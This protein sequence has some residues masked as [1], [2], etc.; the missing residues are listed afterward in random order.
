MR[1]YSHM[2]AGSHHKSPKRKVR[3]GFQRETTKVNY[4]RVSEAKGQ[5]E[6][7]RCSRLDIY[8][9][10]VSMFLLA[11]MHKNKTWRS[12]SWNVAPSFVENGNGPKCG[13][14]ESMTRGLRSTSKTE[15]GIRFAQA[16]RF[17]PGETLYARHKR[18]DDIG[19]RCRWLSGNGAQQEL[20]ST[21]WL[22]Q[23]SLWDATKIA[24]R[25]GCYTKREWLTS[26]DLFHSNWLIW[27]CDLC[28]HWLCGPVGRTLAEFVRIQTRG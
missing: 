27:R 20:D 22:G 11:S 4:L 1:S 5:Y 8:Y 17:C 13:L 3:S 23:I 19:R 10:L 6:Y 25:R 21:T 18:R 9:C 15:L 16:G 12:K 14:V 7:R 2:I 24:Q 28:R 26:H